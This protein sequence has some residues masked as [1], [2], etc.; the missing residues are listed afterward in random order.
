MVASVHQDNEDNI[1]MQV[2]V[3]CVLKYVCTYDLVM[4]A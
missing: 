4:V 1:H 3:F 2:G